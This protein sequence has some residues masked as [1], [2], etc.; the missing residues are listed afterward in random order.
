LNNPGD[1]ATLNSNHLR[2]GTIGL[3]SSIVTFG[4]S[5]EAIRALI[6]EGAK[7]LKEDDE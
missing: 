3:P 2:D 7:A 1:Y 5:P 4:E 6:E